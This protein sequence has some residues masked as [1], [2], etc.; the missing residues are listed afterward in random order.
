ML[1]PLFAKDRPTSWWRA[2]TTPLAPVGKENLK[3]EVIG[4]PQADGTLGEI[5]QGPFGRVRVAR[6]AAQNCN[7]PA[8]PTPV[9][10]ATARHT[11]A[12]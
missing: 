10:W 7:S 2:A 12:R 9:N 6:A 4:D 3:A 11:S 5:G 1:E 8:L